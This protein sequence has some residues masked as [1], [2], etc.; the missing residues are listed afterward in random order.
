M[1]TI[2]PARA[3]DVAIMWGA[4]PLPAGCTLVGVIGPGNGAERASEAL[5]SGLL[6]RTAAGLYASARY[7]G[8]QA[9]VQSEAIAALRRGGMLP[10]VE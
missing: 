8:L 1:K 4:S 6:V 9:V 5:G 10:Q 2:R 3:I 7:H